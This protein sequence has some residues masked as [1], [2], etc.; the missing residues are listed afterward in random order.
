MDRISSLEIV[1]V[2]ISIKNHE[3]VEMIVLSDH[4][5]SQQNIYLVVT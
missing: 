1:P 5:D 3:N 4:G 2:S